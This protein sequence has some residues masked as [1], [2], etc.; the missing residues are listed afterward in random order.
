MLLVEAKKSVVTN[1]LTITRNHENIE[2]KKSIVT[3][4]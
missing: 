2:A 1:I 4:I 3:N